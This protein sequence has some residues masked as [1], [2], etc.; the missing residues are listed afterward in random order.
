MN[1]HGG[2]REGSG[3]KAGGKNRKTLEREA[4][5][6]HDRMQLG[7]TA[8]QVMRF[9]MHDHLEAG[10]LVEAAAIAKDLAPYESPRLSAIAHLPV[11]EPDEEQPLRAVV[12]TTYEEARALLPLLSEASAVPPGD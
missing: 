5:I 8:V 12:V 9:T 1:G 7:P 11:P 3:R 10:R 4:V 2:K 6:E